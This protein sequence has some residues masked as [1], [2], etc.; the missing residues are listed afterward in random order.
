MTDVIVLVNNAHDLIEKTLFSIAYQE[1]EKDLNVYIVNNESKNNYNKEVEFFKKF[2]NI[3]ELKISP[4]LSSGLARQ[5]ALEHSKS[6]FIIFID[7]GDTFASP[8]ATKV[9]QKKIIKEKSD[10]VQAVF[11]DVI[12]YKENNPK[13]YDRTNLYGKI[14]RRKYLLDN[15]IV[16][17]DTFEDE[18]NIFNRLID[19]HSPKIKLISDFTYLHDN[20]K[21][22]NGRRSVVSRINNYI[23]NNIWAL[24]KAIE[25][26]CKK[27]VIARF[28]YSTLVSAYY[29]YVEFIDE[30]RINE[31]VK[32]SIELFDICVKYPVQSGRERQ[33]LFYEQFYY[34]FDDENRKYYLNPTISFVEFMDLIKEEI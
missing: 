17:K 23:E 8:I 21:N 28:A 2:M 7:P 25:T 31:V 33:S 3:K 34:Q 11:V 9:L 29:Y 13:N 20:T 24:N 18:G 19:L 6:E 27:S 14:Y 15:K 4:K 5:Y 22:P 12:N 16:F 1:N 10:V 30:K 26:N 32:N